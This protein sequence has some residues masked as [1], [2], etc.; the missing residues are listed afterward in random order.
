MTLH[1]RH[2]YNGD[3]GGRPSLGRFASRLPSS[4]RPALGGQVAT[5]WAG[6]LK[7]QGWEDGQGRAGEGVG[8]GGRVARSSREVVRRMLCYRHVTRLSCRLTDDTGGDGLNVALV[9]CLPWESRRRTQV[10]YKCLL[11]QGRSKVVVAASSSAQQEASKC[12]ASHTART[13]VRT[14]C[15]Y[16]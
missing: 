11:E 15:K 13:W 3:S 14:A 6:Q 8:G 9:G 12:V 2:R 5:C 16:K 7:G 1:A 4:R 10:I